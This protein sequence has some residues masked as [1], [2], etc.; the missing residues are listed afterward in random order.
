VQFQNI[1][2][3]WCSEQALYQPQ[4][5]SK[6]QRKIWFQADMSDGI[7]VKYEQNTLET[8]AQ[9]VQKLPYDVGKYTLHRH[10]FYWVRYGLFNKISSTALSKN[11]I[12]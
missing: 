1:G 6:R 3:Y 9:K 10:T 7:P 8:I 5:F 2:Y 11:K 12:T 4:T